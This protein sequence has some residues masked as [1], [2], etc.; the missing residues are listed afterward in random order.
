[1]VKLYATMQNICR[2]GEKWFL[3]AVHHY[4]SDDF[5][6]EKVFNRSNQFIGAVGFLTTLEIPTALDFKF[7]KT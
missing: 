1:M 7:N 2:E 5:Y 4:S 3:E 6:Q